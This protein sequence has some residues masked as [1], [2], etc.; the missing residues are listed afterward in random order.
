MN[1]PNTYTKEDVCEIYCHGSI[2]SL[3]RILELTL[4]QGALLAEPGEFTKRAFLNG[5]IDLTQ[6]EAVIDII[7]AKSD[8][9]YDIAIDQMEGLLSSKVN[10]LREQLLNII[11]EIIVG[12]DYPDEDKQAVKNNN[13]GEKLI[14]IEEQIEELIRTA[15]TGKI[16]KDGISTVIVG[17]PNVG[18][19]SLM[20]R[21]LGESR[22][23]V[24]EIP[25]TT[26]DTIEEIVNIEGIPLKLTDTA[27]I[28]NTEDK[29]EKM[30]INKTKDAFNKADLVLLILD[31]DNGIEDS[32]IEIADKIG[33][34][35][36]IVIINKIDLARN[37]D[38]WKIKEIIANPIIIETSLT[39]NIG[40]DNLK[41][42][43]RNLVFAG[44]LR[45]DNSPVVTNIRHKDLLKKTN[46]E[47]TQA[48]NMLNLGEALDF[49][50]VNINQAFEYLGEITGET[51][52][53]DIMDKVFSQFCVGK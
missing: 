7:K 3:K 31:A 18:K 14:Y 35:K 4:D 15:D 34:R 42:S 5:R 52:T 33:A 13:L 41:K 9:G 27:G 29:V 11:A 45:Q 53:D 16:L 10:E 32:D 38:H 28:R 49:V 26:R 8:I 2:V 50:H 36:C 25:G 23:I 12:I 40:I 44:E 47:L 17:K 6:A 20:N 46:N 48:V 30:G 1:A 39:D 19:S 43:I 21:L 51:V 22:A 24:T 37:I